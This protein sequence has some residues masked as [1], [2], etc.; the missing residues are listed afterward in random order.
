M[1]DARQGRS[2]AGR[3][4]SASVAIAVA[5]AFIAFAALFSFT[6]DHSNRGDAWRLRGTLAPDDGLHRAAQLPVAPKHV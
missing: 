3:V 4:P 6:D 5:T 1:R 2:G